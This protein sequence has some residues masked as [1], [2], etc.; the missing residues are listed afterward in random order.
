MK[1]ITFTT[2]RLSVA[3][4]LIFG[5][6]S[7]AAAPSVEAVTVI[8]VDIVDGFVDVDEDGDY[9]A[10]DDLA[11]V[12]LWCN[13]AAPAR[14][15]ILD[16]QFDVNEDGTISVSDDLSNCDLTDEN[17]IGIGV[18]IPTTNQ[19]DIVNGMVDVDEDYLVPEAA[20][21]DAANINLFVLP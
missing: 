18:H 11:N 20:D 12:A 14:V 9:D 21:D 3:M 10:A 19:V 5:L 6:A 17:N 13:D 16:A 8:E 4:A 15:D 1:L 2:P 7:I